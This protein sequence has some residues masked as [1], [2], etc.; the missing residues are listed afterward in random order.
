MPF[1]EPS[2]IIDWLS[3]GLRITLVLGV[4]ILAYRLSGLAIDRLQR[5]VEK[6]VEQEWAQERRERARTLASVGR[7][8]A[9]ALIGLMAGLTIL[10][11][12]G[13]DIGPLL[14]GAGI[15]GLALGFGA[16][17]LVRDFLA[18]FFILLE[19]QFHV[20]DVIRVGDKAGLVEK[21]NLRTTILRDLEGTVHV[22]PNGE[23]GVISNLTKQWA[24]ALIEVEVAY[25]EDVR[26]AI[27]TLSRVGQELAKAPGFSNLIIEEPTVTGVERL[28]ES[29]ITVRLLIKTLPLKQWDVAR[30][31][32]LRIKEA[33]DREGIEIPFPHRKLVF[34][35]EALMLIGKDRREERK[36]AR[37]AKK[38]A[39][40]S[41]RRS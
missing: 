9:L 40:I 38:R 12:L 28:G 5:L 13:L 39:R 27:E 21:L 18:G 37:R 23:M 22:I 36:P 16:Q 30:E 29:G 15:A 41:S 4:A 34:P 2:M 19:D 14:A 26:R 7:G 10:S 24:R 17:T 31:A 33:F 25:Q 11:E 32:R 35:E 8:F 3:S 1:I 6:G 20:G